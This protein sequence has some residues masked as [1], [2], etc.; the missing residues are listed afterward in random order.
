[1]HDEK[2]TDTQFEIC[3]RQVDNPTNLKGKLGHFSSSAGNLLLNQ[4]KISTPLE[5][6]S[7]E[8]PSQKVAEPKVMEG[9]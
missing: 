2:K 1:L 4:A 6:I 8:Q 9:D 7:E 5:M 3:T